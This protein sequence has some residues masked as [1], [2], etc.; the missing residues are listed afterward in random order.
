MPS[1]PPPDYYNLLEVSPTAP[2]EAI[3]A[4][5]HRLALLRH[6]D[7]NPE[8]ANGV[9][10]F[11]H[12]GTAWETLR[13]PAKRGIY[14]AKYWQLRRENEAARQRGEG[15]TGVNSAKRE[16]SN[17]EG[18][19]RETDSKAAVEEVKRQ[20]AAEFTEREERLSR[21]SQWE[22][23]Q[24][25]RILEAARVLKGREDEIREIEREEEAELAEKGRKYSWTG[26]LGSFLSASLSVEVKGREDGGLQRE[27]RKRIKESEL[28]E[29]KKVLEK[30]KRE[31]ELE[32][33][34]VAEEII[35]ERQ[36][37]SG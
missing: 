17:K 29:K 6:P 31:L 37:H 34:R 5:F 23:G 25:H 12:L 4:S 30:L 19:T 13:D 2:L 9:A 22:R 18:V 32:E 24:R 7:K 10:D 1:P 3:K 21:W 20:F 33:D 8:N 27:G 16:R 36:R 15:S 14:D 28:E 11:Q 35:A 26:Y